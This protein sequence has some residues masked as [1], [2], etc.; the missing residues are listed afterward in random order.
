MIIRLSKFV[1]FLIKI[2]KIIDFKNDLFE[3]SIY[4]STHKLT[5]DI[6]LKQILSK[7]KNKTIA[8]YKFHRGYISKKYLKND[9]LLKIKYFLFVKLKKI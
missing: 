6:D 5:Q 8:K 3:I 1:F 7:V 9:K 2:I 4:L